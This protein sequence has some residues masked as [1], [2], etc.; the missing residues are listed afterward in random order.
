MSY[1]GFVSVFVLPPVLVLAL[2]LAA[3]RGTDPVVRRRGLA[4]LGVYVVVALVWTVPWDRWV[5]GRGLWSYPDERVRAWWWGVPAEEFGFIV[6]QACTVGLWTCLVAGR[7][8]RRWPSQPA[9]ARLRLVSAAGWTTVVVVAVPVAAAGPDSA[10]YLAALAAWC[11][12]PAA[13]QRAVGADVLRAERGVRALAVLPPVAYL[14]AADW[15]ALTDGIWMISPDLTAGLRPMGLPVE[16]VVFF[17]VT[18]LLLVD[19]LLLTIHPAVRTRVLRSEMVSAGT[20][21]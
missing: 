9:T 20:T 3:D 2:A 16:E 13:V 10:F 14:C 7:R 8:A 19:G 21:Q 15:W 17:L 6:A 18:S 1:F 4:A 5:I 11:G 12:V